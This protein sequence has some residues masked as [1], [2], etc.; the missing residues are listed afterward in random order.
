MTYDPEL[1]QQNTQNLCAVLPT[2]DFLHYNLCDS[3]SSVSVCWLLAGTFTQSNVREKNTT[4]KA[5]IDYLAKKCNSDIN[6]SVKI[7]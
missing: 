7:A 3:S 4:L 1:Y 5:K 6:I 2:E